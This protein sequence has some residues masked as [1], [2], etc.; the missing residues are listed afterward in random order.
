MIKTI[1]VNNLHKLQQQSGVLLIDVREEHEFEAVAG[2]YSRNYPLSELNV[3]EVLSDLNLS[4]E[5]PNTALYFICRSGARSETAA[6]KFYL[7]GYQ[8]VYNVEGGMLKWQE[9]G[10][11]TRTNAHEVGS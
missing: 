8:H 7:S 3:D 11:P 10:L 5:N 2:P 1:D 9:M 4:S 6:K